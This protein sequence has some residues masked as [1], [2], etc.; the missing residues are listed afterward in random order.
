MPA[1]GTAKSADMRLRRRPKV[2]FTDAEDATIKSKAKAAG[3]TQAKFMRETM[4]AAIAGIEPPKPRR[5][6]KGGDD[7]IIALLHKVDYHLG[8][9]GVNANQIAHATNLGVSTPTR[10]EYRYLANLLQVAASEAKAAM[11]R[12]A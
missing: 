1:K 3:M 9:I 7:E 8:K 10:Q 6:R 5:P 12:I 4:L 2:P 11:E